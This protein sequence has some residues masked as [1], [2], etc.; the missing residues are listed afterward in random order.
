[1]KL[2]GKTVM[3]YMATTTGQE[4]W[5]EKDE[6]KML[7]WMCVVAKKDKTMRVL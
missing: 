1:M 2:K 6:M 7:R 4:A 5:L 3:L